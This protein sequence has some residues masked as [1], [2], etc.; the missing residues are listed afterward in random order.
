MC[1]KHYWGCKIKL[2]GKIILVRH[3]ESDGNVKGKFHGQFDSDLTEKGERQISLLADRLL[4]FDISEIY[5]SDLKRVLKTAQAAAS[6]LG[7]DIKIDPEL[8]EIS[9]GELEDKTW[10]E[11]KEQFPEVYKNWHNNPHIV[12]IPS[13]ESM[14]GFQDRVVKCV[15]RIAKD[16][17]GKN[18]LVA[19]HGT[20]IKVLVCFFTN[21]HLKDFAQVP[22]VDNASITSFKVSED[23]EFSLECLGDIKHLGDELSTL[24]G[25]NWWRKLT[26]STE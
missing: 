16:N 3:G 8:R 20:V 1:K 18:V 26:Q 11:L 25:Q 4:D 9:G 21:V 19:T 15:M 17:I 12:Q 2:S 6:K 10:E 22:W 23:L 14:C 5:S 7:L 24:H 13:G